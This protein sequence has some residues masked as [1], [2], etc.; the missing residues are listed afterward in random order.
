MAA[1]TELTVCIMSVRNDFSHVS[2]VSPTAS[3]LT[4]QTM[5][6]T[7]PS[8]PAASSTHFFNAAGSATSIAP[9]HDLTLLAA[10]ALTTLPTSSALRAQ[11]ATLAP[12]SANSSAIASPMP[13]LPPV[14]STLLPF[15][16]R[17]IVASVDDAAAC[18]RAAGRVVDLHLG[19]V[20]GALECRRGSIDRRLIVVFADQHQPD[21]QSVAHPAG[22]A[23]RR[24]TRCVERRRIGD[25]FECALDIEIA[26]RIGRRDRRRLHWQ[27]RHQQQIVI[28]QRGIVGGAQ[29]SIQ[30][31]RLG[32][33]MTAIVLGKI[34]TDQHRYLETV[35][36][37]IR[38]MVPGGMS[39]QQ[40]GVIETAPVGPHAVALHHEFGGAFRGAG[41]PDRRSQQMHRH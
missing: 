10:S 2:A 21:R 15:N 19:P 38:A 5:V 26:R 12:S 41:E 40:R 6:S 9:P 1:A 8:S 23:H 37:L 27:S 36:Q 16:P 24:M 34:M 29:F 32:I 7:P 33:E 35:V 18:R 22:N 28:A 3:A 30:V 31:L 17:S 25:H 14:T 11:I 39:I 13:L 20:A 4:L